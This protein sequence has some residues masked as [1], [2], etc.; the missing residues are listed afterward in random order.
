MK[1]K[2]LLS[3]VMAA[4]AAAS[5][6]G[7]SSAGTGS[8]T[9][10]SGD[11]SKG[12]TVTAGTATAGTTAAA[13]GESE[14]EGQSR[15]LKLWTNQIKPQSSLAS[16]HESPFHT[17]LEEKTGIKIDYT[18]P[19]P[20]T[21]ENQAFNL[22]LSD[23]DLPDMIWFPYIE[24][25]ETLIEDG[26]LRDLTD[27]LPE[28]APNYWKFLQ[29]NP[30]Y[31]KAMKTDSG[32]YYGFGFFREDPWQSV[33][34][35]PAVRQD[36]LDECGLPMPE[37]IADWETTIRAFNEKYGAKYAFVPN[38]RVAPGVAGAFGAYGTV[39]IKLYVD[40]NDKVQ[41][42]QAQPEWKEL[43][44]WLNKLNQ[45]GLLDP[46][47]VTLDDTGLATKVSN[48]K[49][50]I[51][52]IN[53][54][55]LNGFIQTAKTNG[56]SAKWVGAPYP[57]MEKGQKTTAIFREDPVVKIAAGVTTA[58]PDDL[59]KDALRWYDYPFSEEGY[60]YWNY[61]TEGVSYEMV[62]G[63]P[64][65][66]DLVKNHELGINEAVM[67]YV[68]E[69]GWGCGIQALG[70]AQQKSG[71][72]V[73]AACDTWVSALDG[74]EQA[75]SYEYPSAVTM[76]PD[77]RTESSSIYNMLDTYIEEMALKFITG[78][79]PLDNYDSFI[80]TLNSMGADR[81]LEIR[82]TAYDRYLAR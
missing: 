69:A 31:D 74:N 76:T 66:T 16:W 23:N 36:W 45:E 68:G 62:D 65:F 38:W 18:F 12:E 75:G 13:S 53:A 9:T 27:L 41:L 49:V 56:S 50:G 34:M 14:G 79:E 2:R 70:M 4:T 73:V 11:R 51:T 58:C 44:T 43:I 10:A 63:V 21:D 7:C 52:N 71:P 32:K 35:G 22:M 39:E 40:E 59:L 42:A 82:Q 20:G 47:I 54:G 33:Y 48:D 26:V 6:I 60:L 81:L 28:Y 8:T 61:G 5:L 57:V 3:M 37:T 30:E 78:E 72:D 64:T 15:P 25:A 1:K 19:N 17:G 77:E 67:L 29:E 55:G 24:Q 46:D 80:A